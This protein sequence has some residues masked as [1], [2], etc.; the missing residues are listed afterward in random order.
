VHQ[1]LWKKRPGKLSK[2]IILLYDSTSP[3][4]ADLMKAA[5]ATVGWEIMNHPPY[6]PDLAP[7]HIHLF[8]SVKVHLGGQ[9]FK[10]DNK[11]KCCALNWLHSLDKTLHAA[12]I[13]NLQD[14]GKMCWCKGRIC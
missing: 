11:L 8:G 3:H 5:L 1:A 13:S 14:D 2:I 9:K 7:S 4:I 10:T 12:G 6:S